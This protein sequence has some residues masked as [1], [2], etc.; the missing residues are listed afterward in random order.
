MVGLTKARTTWW[1]FYGALSEI[2]SNRCP[3][4]QNSTSPWFFRL[5]LFSLK[6]TLAPPSSCLWLFNLDQDSGLLEI[7]QLNVVY[8]NLLNLSGLRTQPNMRRKAWNLKSEFTFQSEDWFQICWYLI[9]SNVFP[10]GRATG[11]GWIFRFSFHREKISPCKR[12]LI[13]KRFLCWKCR[14]W[15]SWRRKT[16][17]F[18][19]NHLPGLF[20]MRRWWSQFHRGTTGYCFSIYKF[21]PGNCK[22]LPR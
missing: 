5:K 8:L 2:R 20:L 18:H 11:S 4:A 14:C 17:I 1:Q 16:W 21:I 15:L 22:T 6:S 9:A 13:S 10:A 7:L 12:F 19:H 3:P